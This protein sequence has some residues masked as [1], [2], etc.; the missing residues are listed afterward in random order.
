MPGRPRLAHQLLLLIKLG[1]PLVE[2]ADLAVCS[3]KNVS[4]GGGTGSTK[5]GN[6][7]LSTTKGE[8]LFNPVFQDD[9]KI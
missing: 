4:A 5:E 3:E 6:N 8:V 2:L 7:M 9:D 1:N